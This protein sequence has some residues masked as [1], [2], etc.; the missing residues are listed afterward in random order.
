MTTR[1]LKGA[2]E[3]GDSIKEIVMFLQYSEETV[4]AKMRELGLKARKPSQGAR[5][6]IALRDEPRQGQ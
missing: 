4:R 6:R 3:A 1:D 5:K 2:L